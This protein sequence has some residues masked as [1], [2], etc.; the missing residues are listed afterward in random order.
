MTDLTAAEKRKYVE[1]RWEQ[2]SLYTLKYPDGDAVAVS[3]GSRY[4]SICETEDQAY[5]AAYD[6]T[7]QRRG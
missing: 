4:M 5:S 6:F 2:V 1:E 7:L 3:N